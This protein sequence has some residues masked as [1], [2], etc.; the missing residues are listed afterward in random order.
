M[1]IL[2]DLTVGFYEIP[3]TVVLSDSTH[4][5]I[6]AFELITIRARDADGAAPATPT[7]SAAMAARSLTS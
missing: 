3:L 7:R 2:K 6:K 5:E 4:G 1:A